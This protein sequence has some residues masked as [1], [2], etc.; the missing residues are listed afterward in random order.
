MRRI[1][2]GPQRVSGAGL[3]LPSLPRFLGALLIGLSSAQPL[4]AD[5]DITGREF[6]KTTQIQ[7]KSDIGFRRGSVVVAPIPFSN[8][9]LGSGLALGGAYLF[10]LGEGE[11]TSFIGLGAL[12]SDNGSRAYGFSSSLILASGWNFDV[13]VAD[14]DLRYELFVG[15]NEVAL[16]QTG[17]FGSAGF[18]RDLSQTWRAGA[19]LRYIETRVRP[20]TNALLPPELAPDSNLEIASLGLNLDWDTRDNSDYPTEGARLSISANHAKVL[21]GSR[22]Y[23]FATANLDVYH[24]LGPETVLAARGSICAASDNAPFFDKC[25]IGFSDA[26]RGFSPTRFYDNRLVSGQIE[27]RHRLGNRFG[28]VAFAGAGWT[29]SEFGKLGDAGTRVAG[30]AGLRY[31][32]SKSFPIDFSVD[33]TANNDGENFLYVYVGQ[34][35]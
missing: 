19:S 7:Q 15:S 20:G 18:S 6:E 4:K 28:M 16:N 26:F 13:T 35:F 11:D 24:T 34:R 31:K 10:K 14:A 32:L 12:R 17:T 23:N 3:S 33:Y 27:L 29:G 2:V 21:N 1:P 5:P 25:S 9:V 8:P 30:G 22:D